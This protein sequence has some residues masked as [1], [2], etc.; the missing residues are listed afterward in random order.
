MGYVWVVICFL[1]DCLGLIFVLWLRIWKIESSDWEYFIKFGV[2][3]IVFVILNVVKMSIMS[4][5]MVFL[6]FVWLVL[7]SVDVYYSVNV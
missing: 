6:K 1:I 5:L 4:I 7:I 2:I 3:V